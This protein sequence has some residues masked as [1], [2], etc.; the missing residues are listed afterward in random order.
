[1]CK[2]GLQERRFTKYHLDVQ[3]IVATGY[4]TSFPFLQK[5]HNDTIIPNNENPKLDTKVA[6]IVLGDGKQIRSLYLGT[7]YIDDPTLVVAAG[8]F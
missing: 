3:V 2:Y 8:K 6:P 7:F 1:M 5:Y 4:V